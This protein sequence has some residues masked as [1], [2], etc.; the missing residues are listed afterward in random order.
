MQCT[1][2]AS[3]VEALAGGEQDDIATVSTAYQTLIG[4]IATYQNSVGADR[5]ARAASLSQAGADL[6]VALSLHQEQHDTDSLVNV[7]SAAALLAQWGAS[8]TTV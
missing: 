6:G 3:Y 7:V 8:L 2:I 5:A 1:L 4:G